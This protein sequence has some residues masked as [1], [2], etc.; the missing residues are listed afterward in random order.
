MNRLL[1]LIELSL[2]LNFLRVH[3]ARLDFV[4][5]IV[6]KLVQL[7]AGLL[8]RTFVLLF[9]IV[10]SFHDVNSFDALRPLQI[11]DPQFIVV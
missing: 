9:N 3:E 11:C 4:R 6:R 7:V 1:R 8:P 10:E 5:E 2:S